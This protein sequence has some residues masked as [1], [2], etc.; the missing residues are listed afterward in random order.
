[1][2]FGKRGAQDPELGRKRL[3][4]A[5]ITAAFH[6]EHRLPLVEVIGVGEIA[7]QRVAQHGLR[8]GEIEIQAR[9]PQAVVDAR[10]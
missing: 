10:R 9:P 5:R 6:A 3:P 8:L 4:D 2:R 1:V 7:A